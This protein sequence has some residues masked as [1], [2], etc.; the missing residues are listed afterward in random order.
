MKKRV[1]KVVFWMIA[2]FA[3]LFIIRMIYGYVVY[4][5]GP[6]ERQEESYSSSFSFSNR[7]I[8]TE[9]YKSKYDK[10]YAQSSPDAPAAVDQKYEMISTMTSKTDSFRKDENKV[11]SLIK[12]YNALIQFE[13]NSGNPGKRKIHLAIGVNP[14][15]FDQMLNDIKKVG[16]ITSFQ[17]DKKDKTNEY[18]ELNAKKKTLEKTR[19][20]LI[21]L[22]ERGGSI[23]E[24]IALED[25]ILEVERM[26]QNLGV[27]LGDFDAEN[28]FCTIKFS[29]I[30]SNVSVR[31]ISLMK[32]VLV[33]LEWTLRYYAAIIGIF[34]LVLLSAFVLITIYDKAQKHLLVNKKEE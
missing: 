22:K 30:E 9:K 2:V 17:V 24:L 5:N 11:R 3:V 12:K 4:P 10:G 23:E 13:Q 29:L 19:E 6:I 15:K 18:R 20:S 28:E 16:R 25:R 7:N 34:L 31:T 26:L 21:G 14:S 8:A 27:N 1:L 32:R 33:A